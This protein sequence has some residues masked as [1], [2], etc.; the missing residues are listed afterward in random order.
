MAT[1]IGNS[2]VLKTGA[3]LAAGAAIGEV[4]SWSYEET[5]VL[6]D[7]SAIGDAND[8]FVAGSK[9]GTVE[10]TCHFDPDDTNGQV[11]LAVGATVNVY[12]CGK[13]ADSGDTYRSGSCIVE[14][15]GVAVARNQIIE[16]TFTLRVSGAL[17]SSTVTP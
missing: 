14:R 3:S 13:G 6:V 17:A 7:D 2:G 8:T 11:A 9:S 4:K 16:R 12:L 10:I 1:Y 5:C 15:V